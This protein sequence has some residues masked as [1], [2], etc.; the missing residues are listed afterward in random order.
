MNEPSENTPDESPKDI[1]KSTG[2]PDR[3]RPV[4][5]R[6]EDP[7]WNKRFNQL[8][9][10]LKTGGIVAMV[11]TR[12]GGKTRL[13]SEALR[14]GAPRTGNYTTAMGIFLEIRNS[15]KREGPSELE[16]VTRLSECSLLIIDEMQV[17]GETEWED[18]ILTHVMD[19]R[20]GAMLPTILCANLTVQELK[21]SL[22]T[23]IVSRLNETGAIMEIIGPSHRNLP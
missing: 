4:W 16:I 11:G 7:V 18:R 1:R 12:G 10:I 9:E 2:V 17:R 15:F 14:D 13:A 6:P 22:G 5:P 19:L 8:M 21:E 3:Y 20:Y 23:S